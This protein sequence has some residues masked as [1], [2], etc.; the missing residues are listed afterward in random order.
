[1]LFEWWLT[2]SFESKGKFEKVGG[3]R[4]NH[5]KLIWFKVSSF[6]QPHW[7]P[8]YGLALTYLNLAMAVEGTL[9]VK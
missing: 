8:M 4:F 2:H 9:L 5:L 1:M 7:M 6:G 3:V